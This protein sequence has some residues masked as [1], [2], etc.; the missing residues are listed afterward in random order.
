[1]VT[2]VYVPTGF[3]STVNKFRGPAIVYLVGS[4]LFTP[5]HARYSRRSRASRSRLLYFV[6]SDFA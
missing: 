2:R 6:E 5:L 3:S 4:T 1:M